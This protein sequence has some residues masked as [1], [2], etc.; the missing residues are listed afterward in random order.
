MKMLTYMKF[1][2]IIPGAW[3]ACSDALPPCGPEVIV[4]VKSGKVTALSR[5]IRYQGALADQGYWDNH[6]PGIEN[7]WAM[8][9]VVRWQRFPEPKGAQA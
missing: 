6:Y 1:S 9:S 8:E 5:Y 3:I 2:A 7:R 4:E